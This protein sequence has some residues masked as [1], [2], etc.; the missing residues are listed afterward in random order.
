MGALGPPSFSRASFRYDST[1]DLQVT[2][3]A[4]YGW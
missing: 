2:I 3:A 1:K 4:R